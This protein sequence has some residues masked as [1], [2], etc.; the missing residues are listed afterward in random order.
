MQDYNLVLKKITAN[1]GA[2]K[3]GNVKKVLMLYEEKIQFIGDCCKRFD[4][5][6]YFSTYLDNAVIDINFA[7]TENQKFYDGLLKNNPYLEGITTMVWDDINFR[8]YDVI[9]CIAYNEQRILEY[10]TD[11]Y[12]NL[13]AGG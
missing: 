6:S 5:L 10:L 3:T 4:K 1:A 2:L 12:G 8:Q 11:R 7:G 13:I 9:F